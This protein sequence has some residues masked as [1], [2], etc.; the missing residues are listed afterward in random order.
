MSEL[1][2]VQKAAAQLQVARMTRAGI[3]EKIKID[4]IQPIVDIIKTPVDP[5]NPSKQIKSLIKENLTA[6]ELA[7]VL[8]LAQQLADSVS[9][10]NEPYTFDPSQ[11]IQKAVD[12]LLGPAPAPG[13][14]EPRK[15]G[16]ANLID[17]AGDADAR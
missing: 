14:F 17:S 12:E 13:R 9:I 1:D 8:E 3:E 11:H 15:S 4:A 16:S 7:Q 5:N 2:Q 10:P 6:Q